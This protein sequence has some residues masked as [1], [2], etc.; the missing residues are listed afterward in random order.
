MIGEAAR[1][2]SLF[3]LATG[4][5]IDAGEQ[6]LGQRFCLWHVDGPGVGD[7][8]FHIVGQAHKLDVDVAALAGARTRVRK[9]S[10]R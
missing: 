2:A 3:L 9:T 8:R 5:P 1:A 10:W 6:F 7:G 4:A